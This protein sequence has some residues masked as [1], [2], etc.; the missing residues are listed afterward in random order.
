MMHTV[1][2]SNRYLVIDL[3]RGT[4]VFYF[5]NFH[6]TIRKMFLYVHIYKHLIMKNV[7]INICSARPMKAWTDAVFPTNSP[8]ISSNPPIVPTSCVVASIIFLPE[9]LLQKS[10][11]M[12]RSHF[13][14]SSPMKLSKKRRFVAGKSKGPSEANLTVIQI[15]C[16]IT[17]QMSTRALLAMFPRK[18]VP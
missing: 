13:R 8:V 14:R 1:W 12:K 2:A 6:L 18:I 15:S 17:Q 3:Y 11:T 10:A 9:T 5:N 4:T 7:C 16:D